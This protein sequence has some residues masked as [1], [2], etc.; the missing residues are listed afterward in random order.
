MS[1]TLGQICRTLDNPY[2]HVL[3]FGVASGDTLTTITNILPLASNKKYEIFGFDS[4]EGLP[5]D[6]VGTTLK[7]GFFNLGGKIPPRVKEI[8]ETK[9]VKIYPGWF[10]NT[11]PEYLKIAKD[12]ALLHVD[13]D[14]YSSTKTVL[15]G[16]KDYI[17][18]GTMIVFDEWF[19]NHEDK[20]ENRQHEQKCFFE[21]VKD[22]NVK[23][24]YYPP[25]EPERQAIKIIKI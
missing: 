20:E 2:T 9:G 4:F 15:Y 18:P 25:L 7:K 6:W 23:F 21:W 10:E 16:L 5:E 3:E 11:L 24:E 1:L 14:L 19:Y 22:F 17:K 12:I 8:I 13:C